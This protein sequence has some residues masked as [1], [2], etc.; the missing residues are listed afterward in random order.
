MHIAVFGATGR[1]GHPLGEQPLER[2][3]EAVAPVRDARDLPSTVREDDRVTDDS[4]V[5]NTPKIT[6]DR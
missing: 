3:H 5:N 4:D 2:S 6:E 1:T